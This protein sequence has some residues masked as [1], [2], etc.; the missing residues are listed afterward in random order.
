MT[1]N[2]IAKYLFRLAP[3]D[4]QLSYDNSGFLVGHGDAGVTKVLL[5]LDVTNDVIDEAI[6]N[7]VQL[8]VSHHPLIWDAMKSVTDENVR[9]SKVMRLIE[10]RIAVISL[11]TNLDIAEGGVND[12]LIRLFGV[13]PKGGVDEYNCGRWGLLDKPTT[14]TEFLPICRKA[15]NTNGLRYHDAGLPVQKIAVLGGAG[16][17]EISCAKALGCDTYITSDIKYS[18]FIYAK[19]I[20]IN[21]IDGDHFCTEAPVMPVLAQKLREQFPGIEFNISA[22]HKQ[23]ARFA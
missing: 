21:I 19:E 13:E 7:G 5:A 11:H 4:L 14:M 2:D 12:V 15:L 16:G 9:Q 1:V 3:L 6:D 23:T 17:E 8:I 10:N 18:D 20:G 22:V